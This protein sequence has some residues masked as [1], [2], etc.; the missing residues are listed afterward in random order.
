MSSKQIYLNTASCGLVDPV[1]VSR[2]NMLYADFAQNS[3]TRSE[4]WR[5]YEEGAIRNTIAEF[6]GAPAKNV[7]MVPNFSWAL[8]GIVQSLK[9]T[10]RVLLYKG[11]YPSLLEPFKINNFAITWVEAPDGFNMDIER[12]RTA[13]S[14]R[15]VDIVALSHVQWS[16]GYKTD[17]KEIG[18]L[19]KQHG[20]LF[21]ADATQAMGANVIDLGNLN[22]DVF[23]SSNYKWMN[24]GF[25]TGILYVADSFLA[26]YPPVV[27]GHN[28]YKMVNDEWK[29]MPS[30]QSYEPGHP[31]MFGLTVLAEAIA[32]K[33][34]LGVAHIEKHNLRLTSVL[35]SQLA[36]LPVKILGDHTMNN[37]SPI[38]YL[39]DE[40]DLGNF[41]KQHNIVVTH[42]NGYL[43]VSMHYYNTA[44]D[45]MALVNCIDA[46]YR[47]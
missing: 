11:D 13:I 29:Y 28:S 7:A 16:S 10:E 21:I 6:I 44:D 15:E 43:R 39:L 30:A 19:C 1:T 22:I 37:R 27:G 24:A 46:F 40:H 2:A 14:N 41:I 47:R 17:L 38:V 3:S 9:G 31:N 8:N 35:V 45:V 32:H 42:R 4:E 23:A 33:N 20:V 12:V 18:E 26:H 5:T 36:D 34:A 25:G